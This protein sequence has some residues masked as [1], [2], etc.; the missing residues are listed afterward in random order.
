[1]R[2]LATLLAAVA[3]AGCGHAPSTDLHPSPPPVEFA[4]LQHPFR[5]QRLHLDRDSEASRWQAANGAGWLDPITSTPQARWINGPENVAD[6]PRLA[7]DARRQRALLV[8]VAY[9]LPD[10]GCTGHRDGAPTPQAYLAW[11][12]Q[13]VAA[14]AGTRA[15]IIVEPDAI[16]AD[17]FD[18]ERADLLRTAVARLVDA[19]QYVYL[20]AGHSAWRSTGE[21][22]ERLLAS[23]VNR[24]EGFAVNVANRQ[25]T[26]D[27]QRWGLELSDLVGG[28]EFVIDTSRNGAGPPPDEPGRD[29][30]WCNPARQGLGD[31]P[32]TSPDLPGVAATLWVKRPGESDGPCGGET[33]YE[34][35]P[36]Q[37]RNLIVNAAPWVTQAERQSAIATPFTP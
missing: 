31:R 12:D 26:Q 35:A 30:E 18:A 8:L 28:R 21:T 14:L 16:P 7:R 10:R 24:A 17:C 1:M 36:R 9:Y 27:A 15:A 37:A 13:L 25:P 6:I 5:G 22:A 20:D 23:G 19:G 2:R 32:T 33:T 29:D 34:F 11:I 4:P 3:L